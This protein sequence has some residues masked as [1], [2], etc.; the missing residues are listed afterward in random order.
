M[1]R[2]LLRACLGALPAAAVA[3]TL[4]QAGPGPAP[5]G[6]TTTDAGDAQADAPA[7]ETG[8]AADAQPAPAEL[9]IQGTRDLQSGQ[10]AITMGDPQT[11]KIWCWRSGG[12][13]N[14]VAQNAD[15]QFG[16]AVSFDAAFAPGGDVTTQSYPSKVEGATLVYGWQASV[17]GRANM[18]VNPDATFTVHVTQLTASRFAGTFTGPIFDADQLGAFHVQS[19]SFDLPFGPPGPSG[20]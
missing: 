14:V 15:W 2:T 7:P 17:P 18:Y 4:N 9:S 11:S 13:V 3:C 12:V 5:E 20:P 19:A 10:T 1:L 6:P 16:L 8:A